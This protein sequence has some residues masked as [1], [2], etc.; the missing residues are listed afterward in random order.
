MF[1]QI[2]IKEE[3]HRR[4]VAR[5][6]ASGQSIHSIVTLALDTYLGTNPFQSSPRK[7]PKK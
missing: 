4:L 3:D 5:K 7:R 2:A 6:S 1:K